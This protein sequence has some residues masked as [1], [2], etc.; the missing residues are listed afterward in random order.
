M[1]PMHRCHAETRRTFPSTRSS[2]V[3][4][5]TSSGVERPTRSMPIAADIEATNGMSVVD[6]WASIDQ[7]GHVA[8]T[9]APRSAA[10]RL[11]TRA[12]PA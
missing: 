5:S 11:E 4:T 3:W 1:A 2:W 6:W 12:T 7:N 10:R 8:R 9:S